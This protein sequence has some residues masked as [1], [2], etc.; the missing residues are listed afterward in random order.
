[1]AFTMRPC[2][3]AIASLAIALCAS[4]AGAAT[5]RPVPGTE[6]LDIDIASLQ[7]DGAKAQ[8]WLRW[9]GK[10]P[11]GLV[12]AGFGAPPPAAHRTAAQLELDCGRH[13]LRL[14]ASTSFDA[15]GRALAMTS[16]PAPPMLVPEGDLAWAYDAVCEAMRAS[17]RS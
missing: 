11:A 9:W 16:T 1:M 2:L 10:P 4:S 13:A 5:W 14:L 7:L 17:G 3:H 15:R 6:A 12:A 8:A